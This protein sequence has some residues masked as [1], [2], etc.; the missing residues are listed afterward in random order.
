MTAPGRRRL[1]AAMM[2]LAGLVFVSWQV[3]ARW[4]RTQTRAAAV[5]PRR[6]IPAGEL[7]AVLPE[8]NLVDTRGRPISSEELRGKTL[9]VDYWAPWC[10]PCEKEMPGYQRLYEKYRDRGLLVVGIVFDPGMKMGDESA[11][12]F[13]KRLH[14]TYPLVKDSAAL[15]A[16][17]G[18]IQGIPTTFVIDRDRVI[19]YKI[20]G[21]EYTTNV[22]RALQ[23]SLAR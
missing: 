23:A 12:H 4:W 21:F 9:L 19:R 1:L 18:G 5:L 8:L 17:F 3:A 14:I 13:A 2:I 15:Q 6:S 16:E 20:V 22:E 7:G 10:K 11:E